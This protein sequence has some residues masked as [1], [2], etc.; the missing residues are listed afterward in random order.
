MS[1]SEQYLQARTHIQ[2]QETDCLVFYLQQAYYAHDEE[3]F[4]TVYSEIEKKIRPCG[5][6]SVPRFQSLV[7]WFQE[8]FS[9]K[10]QHFLKQVLRMLQIPDDYQHI[11][12]KCLLFRLIYEF[13]LVNVLEPFLANKQVKRSRYFKEDYYLVCKLFITGGSNQCL[14]M[15]LSHLQKQLGI[16]VQKTDVFCQSQQLRMYDPRE[17]RDSPSLVF[18]KHICSLLCDCIQV[19]NLEVMKFLIEL[20]AKFVPFTFIFVCLTN[21]SIPVL[22]YL[23]EHKILTDHELSHFLYHIYPEYIHLE[24]YECLL[25]QLKVPFDIKQAGR[26]WNFPIHV[27]ETLYSRCS[28]TDQL[29]FLQCILDRIKRSTFEHKFLDLVQFIFCR[30]SNMNVVAYVEQLL[31]TKINMKYLALRCEVPGVVNANI[32]FYYTDGFYRKILFQDFSNKHSVYKFIPKLMER[33]DK[34]REYVLCCLQDFMC[35]DVLSLLVQY[36]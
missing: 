5:S 26:I 10:N 29:V 13:D 28:S 14:Y 6:L 11:Q 17:A 35:K 15:Y 34:Y 12:S 19:G 8:Q 1:L 18:H 4:S 9:I 16:Q 24:A 33:L 23:K 3:L 30:D 31:E 2:K 36:V 22:Q 25:H 7:Q 20:N 27:L 32:R 21:K